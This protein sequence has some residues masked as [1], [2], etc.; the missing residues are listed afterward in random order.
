VARRWRYLANILLLAAFLAAPLPR[1]AAAQADPVKDFIASLTTQEKVGQLF[2]V[3]FAG[4]DV[5]KAS[6]IAR[7]VQRYRIGGVIL[8]P[9]KGN[10]RNEGN[11][12]ADV[13]RMAQALQALALENPVLPEPTATPTSTPT[14]TPAEFPSALATPGVA[15]T[16]AETATPGPVVTPAAGATALTTEVA[17]PQPVHPLPLF[18]AVQEDGD[19]YP[20][21]SIRSGMTPLP[22]DM[23]IGATWHTENALAVGKIVGAELASLGVNMLLGPSLDVLQRPRSA[24]PGDIGVRSFSGDP[25]WAGRMGQA[26][27]SGVHQGSGGKVI[28]V[29]KYFPGLGSSDRKATEEVATVQKSL[30]EL[31]QIE[32]APFFTV[33]AVDKR[34]QGAIDASAIT[35]AMMTSPLIRYR[36]FQGNIRQLTRP[37]GLDADGMAALMSLPEFA[38][39]RQTGLLVSGELGLPAVRRFYDP[40]MATF[41]YK[42]IAQEA[43][44]AGNDL[45]ILSDFALENDWQQEVANI[46]DTLAFFADRYEKDAGFRSRVDASLE[47]IVRL[48]LS[49]YPQF[50]LA[51]VSQ[52]PAPPDAQQS[53][54]TVM[55]IS[56]DALT[57]IYPGPQELADRLPGPPLRDEKMLIF[58]DVRV[59]SDCPQCPSF[60]TVPQD[61]LEQAILRLYGPSASGQALAGNIQSYSFQALSELLAAEAKNSTLSP[62]QAQLSRDLDQAD[63][64]VFLMQDV[65][66]SVD[67]YSDAVKQF[68]KQRSDW[69]RNKRLIVYALN[70]PYFLD[71]TEVSKLTAYY[72]LYSK[73]EPFIETAARSLYR[74][75]PPRGAPPVDVQAVNYDLISRLEPD[76]N[77]VIQINVVSPSTEQG[78]QSVDVKVGSTLALRTSV[79]ADHNGNPVPD[80]TPVQFRLY[81]PT[82][83]LELPR[84]SVTT[85]GGVAETSITLDRGGQLEVSLLTSTGASS[86]TLVVSIQ[87]NAPGTIATIVPPTATPEPTETPTVT[88]SPTPTPTA[89]AT[90][91]VTPTVTA[92]APTATPVPGPAA[93]GP[94]G[95]LLAQGLLGVVVGDVL[96]N[97]TLG[98][99]VTRRSRRLRLVLWSLV[100][101]LLFYCGYILGLIRVP[102]LA[103]L[104]RWASTALVSG[105]AALLPGLAF[106]REER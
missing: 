45:I 8:S 4:D 93:A 105:G 38:P 18:I 40:Q 61:A 76:P 36:G 12:A 46:E 26:Y 106:L 79:I 10:I 23:S 90:A 74:E 68:L 70:A 80:G 27:I 103:A 87:G 19:G 54:A 66:T 86:T 82:E 20:N 67:P 83:T 62:A 5:S 63:W 28:T 104:P 7:L 60:A 94:R 98:Y 75:L 11:G 2:L 71:T 78:A 48:K 77:Q 92:T 6:D 34:D 25:F 47:R 43:F 37:I 91:T 39:W 13:K 58:T 84:Q 16:P 24:A 88:P 3:A 42:R 41:P 52:L 72:A 85:V 102:A 1:P 50:T 100:F 64:L 21:S 35:D 29:A 14:P 101:G 30:Q 44:M 57:L 56:Q 32:L 59:S 69:M 9:D 33:T 95:S 53:A 49:L 97:L 55:H 81:Y 65:D 22:S 15:L 31:R 96:A 51:A 73:T 99:R 17:T 89:T